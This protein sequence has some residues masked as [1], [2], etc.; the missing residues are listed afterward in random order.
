MSRQP[1]RTDIKGEAGD[2]SGS[3]DRFAELAR[4][5]LNLSASEI[6]EV[7]RREKMRKAEI[8]TRKAQKRG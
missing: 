6:E 1:R 3:H 7:R 8:E 2:A 5:L 4:G